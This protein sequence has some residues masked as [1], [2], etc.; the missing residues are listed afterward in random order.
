MPLKESLD[1]IELTVAS[2]AQCDVIIFKIKLIF[3]HLKSFFHY[4]FIASSWC[5]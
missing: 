5:Q 1:V 2:C 3:Y 4:G